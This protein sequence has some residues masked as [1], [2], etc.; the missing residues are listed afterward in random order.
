MS[1]GAKPQRAETGGLRRSHIAILQSAPWVQLSVFLQRRI[2]F[3]NDAI[4]SN[5]AVIYVELGAIQLQLSR[6][7]AFGVRFGSGVRSRLGVIKASLDLND[8]SNPKALAGLMRPLIDEPS[9]RAS[10]QEYHH[11]S[12]PQLQRGSAHWDGYVYNA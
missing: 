8:G 12:D 1:D 3:E 6:F 5:I 4:R 11:V 7:C 9:E 2:M 10:L